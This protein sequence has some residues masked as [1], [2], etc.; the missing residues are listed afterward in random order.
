MSETANASSTSE[1]KF[2]NLRKWNIALGAL[3]FLQGLAMLLLSNNF[4]IGITTNFLGPLAGGGFG[5]NTEVIFE[6]PIGAAISAFL[7][8]SAIAHFTMAGPLYGFYVAKLKEK[9]NYIR[10][11][12]YSFSSSWMLVIIALL[13]GIFDIG[14][15]I[16]IFGACAVM[17]LC[18]MLME[19]RNQNREKV[20][21]M[22]FWVGCI[23]GILPWMVLFIYFFGAILSATDTIPTFVYFIIISLFVVFNI[24]P[25]NMVLQYKRYGKWDDYLYGERGY[26]IM[27]LVAKSLLAWQVFSGTLG[28]PGS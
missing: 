16:L 26:M 23:A 21:W 14:T 24:F 8:M 17:N 27:S 4:K 15:L 22:P 25:L 10:W 5:T 12:E 13:C 9:I 11:I 2:L 19:M 18:G 7:F 1:D 6:L 20:D 3:H 28:G